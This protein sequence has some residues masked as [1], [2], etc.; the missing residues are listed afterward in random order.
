M[1]TRDIVLRLASGRFI[2]C[3]RI[4]D[5]S[6]TIRRRT[7]LEQVIA[8][9]TNRLAAWEA[10]KRREGFK[11]LNVWVKEEKADEVKAFVQKLNNS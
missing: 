2:W 1:Q 6:K 4:L 8:E 5:T 7:P 10:K 9:K 11:R 3:L